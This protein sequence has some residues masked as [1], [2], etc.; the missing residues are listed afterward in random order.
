[1]GEITL[2]RS[3]MI[4]SGEIIPA[5]TVLKNYGELTPLSIAPSQSVTEI[6]KSTQGLR[7]KLIKKIGLQNIIYFFRIPRECVTPI[8]IGGPLKKE[9]V[10]GDERVSPF[11]CYVSKERYYAEE[12]KIE[13]LLEMKDEYMSRSIQYFDRNFKRINVVSIS[14]LGNFGLGS[15]YKF[16]ELKSVN[17]L[18]DDYLGFSS[19][20]M[21]Y[22]PNTN[23]IKVELFRRRKFYVEQP[24]YKTEKYFDELNQEFVDCHIRDS[25]HKF[26]QRLYIMEKGNNEWYEKFI[27]AHSWLADT[28]YIPIDND[29]HIFGKYEYYDGQKNVSG[30]TVLHKSNNPYKFFKSCKRLKV[31]IKDNSAYY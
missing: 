19:C 18:S 31:L 22:Y 8:S 17:S 21:Y 7:K 12:R 11:P 24:S 1:M 23:Q 30:L 3:I 15:L 4:D 25:K 20:I 27:S 13:E 29:S 10:K 16:G 6:E 9:W 5:G 26:C 28:N 14:S 2:S